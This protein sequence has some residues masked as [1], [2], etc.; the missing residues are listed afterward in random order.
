MDLAVLELARLDDLEYAFQPLYSLH[1]GAC[2]GVEALLRRYRAV[3]AATIGDFFDS[4]L[5]GGR[6]AEV[7][8]ILRDKAIRRFAAAGFGPTARLFFNLDTRDL[9]LCTS[10]A[11]ATEDLLRAQGLSPAA[12][13]FEL[14]EQS[15]LFAQLRELEASAEC[16]SRGF[17]LAIDDFGRTAGGIRPLYEQRPDF[18]KIDRSLFAGTQVDDRRRSVLSQLVV[19]AHTLGITVVAEG[20]E[21]D[22]ELAVCKEI[23]CDLAQGYLFCRPTETLE[24]IPR[25]LDHVSELGRRGQPGRRTDR[26]FIDEHMETPPVLTAGEN[27][28]MVFETFRAH[29]HLNFCP[30]VDDAG[31]PLGILR[32]TDLKDYTYSTYGRDLMAN[33]AFG[34]TLRDFV[35]PCPIA[36]INSAAES[37]LATFSQNETPEGILITE[38]SIYRGFLS[39]GALLRVINEKNLAQARDQNPLTR[40]PGNASIQ[41]FLAECLHDRTADRYLVYFDF[42]NFKPFNDTFGFRQGDRA[43]LLFA[44][45]M[46]QILDTDDTFLGHV[47]GDDFF[48]AFRNVA[49]EQVLGRVGAVRTAFARDVESFYRPEDRAQGGLVARDRQGAWRTFPLL[50][51]SAAVLHLMPGRGD[52]TVDEMVQYFGTLKK[53]AKASADGLCYSCLVT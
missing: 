36:D 47:G 25:K 23:G 37:I 42:D 31:R 40:L 33:R 39:T 6:L 14:A 3:G 34:K 1:S 18:V 48:A 44:D 32:E 8:M 19:M 11:E 26:L 53:E 9:G 52:V 20:V 29:K 38:D 35:S 10:L 22:R 2:L 13:V 16:R 17:A 43:I 5:H 45:L 7:D 24:G 28:R 46:R 41:D 51:A 27:M 49:A 4:A 21:S 50:S 12:M 30:V 15:G